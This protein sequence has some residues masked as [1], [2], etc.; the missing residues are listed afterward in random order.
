MT[1]YPRDLADF[2]RKTTSTY[3]S[4]TVVTML[5]EYA[6]VYRGLLREVRK[7]APAKPNQ[8]IVTNFRSLLEQSR[9]TKNDVALQDTRNALLFL[10]SQREHQ[11]LVERYN[12]ITSLTEQERIRKTANRVGLDVPKEATNLE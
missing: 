1:A 4:A 6:Q 3:C 10:K 12:P 9:K 11:I 7:A 8:T 5:S 2:S